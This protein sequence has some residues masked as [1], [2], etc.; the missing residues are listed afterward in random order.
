[1]RCCECRDP[2]PTLSHRACAVVVVAVVAVI[3]VFVVVVVLVVA[4]VLVVVVGVCL[5]PLSLFE[6][7]ERRRW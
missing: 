2:I 7:N 1:M 4:A 5:S 3:V 6:S